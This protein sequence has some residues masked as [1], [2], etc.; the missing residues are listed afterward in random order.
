MLQKTRRLLP[1]FKRQFHALPQADKFV[2]T[3]EIK[4]AIQNQG[5][6]V[7]LESTI[8]SHG[9]PYPQNVETART[10]EDIIRKEGAIPA[11]IALLDGKV[12][13]GLTDKTLEHLGKVGR[14]AQ[15]TSRRDLSMV[16]SQKKVGAT[17]VASTMILARAAGI[18]IFVTGGIGGVH[19]GA[20][21]S[22]DISA[23]LTELGRTPV[24]VVCAGVKSI[25]DISKTLEVL[26]T[27]GVT[28]TTMGKDKTFPAF[29][30]PDSGYKSPYYLDNPLDAAKSILAN[31]QLELNS[32]MVFACPIPETD[33]ADTKSI[34]QA[35]DTAVSEARANGVVGKEETPFLLKR[36]AELT[37]G[38]SLAANIALVKNNAHIGAR[39]AVQLA[40]LKN[41]E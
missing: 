2:I 7:A 29:Y 21:E 3:P 33:A 11:T 5:P 18:P 28:V 25:L 39:I 37:Q 31:H 20:E 14:E 23:D 35:I 24:A 1:I 26:E 10:V 30:T 27:Q 34:Q 22:F 9:M 8:I 41:Y 36:I 32:G 4:A 40:K 6:V 15:K 19:R 16:L 13:I 12:H 38:E 17:T